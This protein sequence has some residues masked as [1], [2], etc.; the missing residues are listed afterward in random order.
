MRTGLAI[1]AEGTEHVLADRVDLTHQ[2]AGP[3]IIEVNKRSEDS[4]QLVLLPFGFD[5]VA[6]LDRSC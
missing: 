6:A 5:F 1:E 4:N 2:G 3:H